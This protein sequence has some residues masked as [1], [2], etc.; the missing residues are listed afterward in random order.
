M[1][2]KL[3]QSDRI[4]YSESRTINVGQYENINTH[5]SYTSNLKHFNKVDKTIEI[6]YSESSPLSED[7][8]DFKNTAKL[9]MKRVKRVLNTR[10]LEVRKAT[11]EFVETDHNLFD[12]AC[13]DFDKKDLL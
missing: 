8:E 12:K 3:I 9:L 2:D 7:S 5:F 6:K 13:V 1:S 11:R 4:T 10:E